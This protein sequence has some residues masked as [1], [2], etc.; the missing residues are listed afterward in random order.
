MMKKSLSPW[1]ESGDEERYRY[2]VFPHFEGVVLVNQCR[3]FPS[4]AVKKR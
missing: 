1:E 4:R 3:D 2:V